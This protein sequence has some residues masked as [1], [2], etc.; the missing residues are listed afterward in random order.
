MRVPTRRI[1][2]ILCAWLLVMAVAAHAARPQNEATSGKFQPVSSQA[3]A[4]VQ[5]PATA[6]TALQAGFS[7]TPTLQDISALVSAGAPNLALK[8]LDRNQPDFSRDAVGW[9]AWERERI[10]LYQF[11]HAWRA[12]IAR[13]QRLPAGVGSDFR[14]WEKMQAAAAWLQ[15]DHGHEARRILRAIIWSRKPPPDAQTLSR[16]RQLVIQSYLKDRRLDDAQTAVIR[17]RQDYP[18]DTGRWPLLEARLFLRTR[19][20]RA[21]LDALRGSHGAD[22]DM[23]VLL[24]AL[25]AH[26]IPAAKVMGKAVAIGTNN[27]LPMAE[28]VHA[29]FIAAEAAGMLENPVARIQALQN[30]LG[31]Q[32]G[33]LGQDAVFA[34]TPGMLWDA[35]LSYGEDLGNRLQLVVGDEQSWFLAASNRFYSSPV[36]ACALFSVVAFN[37]HA[38]QQRDVAHWQFAT[39]VQ[40]QKY[41]DVV[42]RHLYLD[43]SRFKT[44]SDIP[45]DVRYILV[46]DVLNIP[47]IPL[48]SKLMQ[49][50]E[51]PPPDTDP[52]A[53]QLQRAHVFI[54]GGK[55]DA[56]IR[57]LQQ[58]FESGVRVDPG[59]VLP[60]L[61]DL[62]T[63]G[64]NRDAIPFFKTL[65]RDNLTAAQ[66]RQM[67]YWIADSYKALGDY[68]EAAELYLRSATLLDPYAMDQ[69]AQSARYQAAQMLTRAGDIDDART[70]YRGLL[71]ATSDP[72]QQA[73]L[74]HDLQQLMLMPDKPPASGSRQ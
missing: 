56:G 21:A 31:L 59:D 2:F 19:Q 35:Y 39:L 47:D 62:Q 58:L 54:L 63:I 11:T 16:L 45:P 69:W 34:I 24:A 17:Y 41:G 12:I 18:G 13:A 30:G 66:A 7:T 65:L 5:P 57:A 26:A 64:R 40:K 48:A 55:P 22:A 60:L 49:G 44:V 42:L 8:F 33:L 50:L 10:Y 61:F 3:T 1:P 68:T 32:P 4:S 36:R 70:L 28:R 43:S 46:N 37:A 20:P 25:R 52:A 71:N 51:Q 6:Q 15:L 38:A 73:I 53:W 9:M 72:S 29:W 23:L 14:E 67:F 27:K 74:R